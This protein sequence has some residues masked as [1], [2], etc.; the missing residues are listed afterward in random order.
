MELLFDEGRLVTTIAY[1]LRHG[2]SRFALELDDEG[3]TKFDDLIA[4]IR[5]ERYEWTDLNAPTAKAALESMDRFEFRGD[6]I[7]AAYGHSV[8]LLTP[9]PIAAPPAILF[10]GTAADNVA[11]I[12]QQGVRKMKRR[13]VH[14]SAD[15][16]W[17]IR[18][19]SDKPTRTIL[20]VNTSMAINAGVS[21]RRANNHVWLTDSVPPTLLAIHS[22][23]VG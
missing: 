11:S 15:L 21:F 7:R 10:H 8:E 2:P 16:D 18:F 22:Q 19:L 6:Y 4:A 13:F 3:W 12:F 17:V 1:A 20:A 14:L 9:P 23:G 5:F